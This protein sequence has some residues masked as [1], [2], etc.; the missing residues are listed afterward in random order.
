MIQS[1]KSIVMGCP[2]NNEGTPANLLLLGKDMPN[3]KSTTHLGLT[4]SD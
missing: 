3:V 1:D 4:M 2:D